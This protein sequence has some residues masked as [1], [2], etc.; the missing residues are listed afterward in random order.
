V[1]IGFNAQYV[2]DFL[3]A[4]G[5]ESVLMELK[6]GESQGIFRPYGESAVDYRYVVMPMRL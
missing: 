2:L 1:E 6:D 4:V 3:G 5:G